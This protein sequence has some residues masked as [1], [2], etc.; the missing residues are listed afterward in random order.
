M[1]GTMSG[2]SLAGSSAISSS[3]TSSVRVNGSGYNHGSGSATISSDSNGGIALNPPS[4]RGDTFAAGLSSNNTP[5][6]GPTF[7][8]L[9]PHLRKK[10]SNESVLTQ[11]S[12]VV[13]GYAPST[14]SNSTNRSYA[15]STV[16]ES[17]SGGGKFAKVKAGWKPMNLPVV[18]QEREEAAPRKR[19]AEDD[20][21]RVQLSDSDS[22]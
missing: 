8:N 14:V 20:D 5:T 15:K 6:G 22:E 2:M 4:S 18:Q 13:G 10:Q 11:T 16:S 19:Q 12:S 7:R 17:T 3:I 9:P 1:T 21:A